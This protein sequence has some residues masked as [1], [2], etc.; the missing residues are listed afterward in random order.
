MYE[1]DISR[2]RPTEECAMP[3]NIDAL[4]VHIR[5][6]G[7]LPPICADEKGNIQDGHHRYE[8]AKRLGIKKVPVIRMY[9]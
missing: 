9:I 3:G 4:M 6:G 7:A 8:A 5:Q 1:V 2:L